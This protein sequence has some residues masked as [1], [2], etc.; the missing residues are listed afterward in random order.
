MNKNLCLSCLIVLTLI[1]SSCSQALF[2]G[3]LA[4]AEEQISEL[5]VHLMENP[6]DAEALRDLGVIY[7]Q[8]RQFGQ[9]SSYLEQAFALEPNDPQTLYN[10]GLANETLSKRDTALRLYEKFVDVPRSSQYRRLMEGRYEWLSQ[11]ILRD[12]IQK[13]ATDDPVVGNETSSR[14]VAVFPFSYQGDEERFEPLARGFAELVSVDLANVEEIRVV[15]RIRLQVLL[16]ELELSQSDYV[17]PSTAPRVGQL[18]GAGRLI[19]GS[20]NVI[21]KDNL[22]LDGA[23]LDLETSN[24]EAVVSQSDG[25]RNLFVMQKTFV[26]NLVEQM[27][28][29]LT[30]VERQNIEF[31]PTQNIQAF[32]AYSRGLREEDS[33]AYGMAAGFYRRASRLDP[34]FDLAVQAAERASTMEAADM[35]VSQL[36]DE[37]SD[38]ESMNMM[39]MDL[40]GLRIEMMNNELG[41][42]IVPGEESREPATETS[43]GGGILPNPPRPP[44]PR[45]N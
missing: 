6:S 10:L 9:A 3:D 36:I 33:G 42:G 44:A 22:R 13:I 27:G 34:N 32:L 45:N 8:A 11:R 40:M 41:S 23:F 21:G 17:D 1:S 4:D 19:T 26:F 16:D 29:T 28:I 12:Q 39:D 43:G 24:V 5:K 18:L 25:L 31:I 35:E 15:E 2:V 14:I 7:L 38:V 20:Y 30:P 37:S